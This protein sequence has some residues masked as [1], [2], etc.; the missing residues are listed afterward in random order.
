MDFKLTPTDQ[1]LSPLEQ[2]DEWVRQ[3]GDESS[4]VRLVVTGFMVKNN[5]SSFL[6]EVINGKKPIIH[7][8][9]LRQEGTV[10]L[11]PK[12]ITKWSKQ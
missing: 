4:F 8:Q 12:Q 6:A 7:F 10:I 9:T 11:G 2:Y 1:E 5:A 3:F